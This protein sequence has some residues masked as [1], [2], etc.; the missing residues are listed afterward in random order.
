[1]FKRNPEQKKRRGVAATPETIA[2]ALGGLPKAIESV[3]NSKTT[4]SA[5]IDG[6][7]S[8]S[9]SAGELMNG[10]WNKTISDES[11]VENSARKEALELVVR[12]MQSAQGAS[13]GR[14]FANLL[15]G[16]NYQSL[17]DEDYLNRM[18]HARS[19]G[20]RPVYTEPL[21]L[22][23]S[24]AYSNYSEQGNFIPAGQEGQR[25]PINRSQVGQHSQPKVKINYRRGEDLVP[26]AS[27]APRSVPDT[28]ASDTGYL[29]RQGSKGEWESESDDEPRSPKTVF[30]TRKNSSVYRKKFTPLRTPGIPPAEAN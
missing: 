5:R 6:I 8:V 20:E 2:A 16:K 19:L 22:G 12:G 13:Q 23:G 14:A 15:G 21:Q 30:G 18:N 9:I 25:I 26:E 1:M 3:G 28:Y 29:H 27:E 24:D 4:L 7:G 10:T 11:I 17:T